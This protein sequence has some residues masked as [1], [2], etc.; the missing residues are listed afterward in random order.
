MKLSASRAEVF[1]LWLAHPLGAYEDI[2]QGRVNHVT[3]F[4]KLEKIIL[5][6]H[7]FK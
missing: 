5:Y 6:K 7:V 1:I 2:S 4:V 3:E